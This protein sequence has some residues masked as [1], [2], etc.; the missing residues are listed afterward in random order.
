MVDGEPLV[1][2][3]E[4]GYYFVGDEHDF[5]FVTDLAY[6]GEVIWWWYEDVVGVDDC[7]E[8]DRGHCVGFF[9]YEHVL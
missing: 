9:D 7:F 3:A 6:S 2:A 8:Q 1:V 4:A 5:V